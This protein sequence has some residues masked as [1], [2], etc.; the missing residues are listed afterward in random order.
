MKRCVIDTN[1]MVTANK[2]VQGTDDELI[3]K[4]PNLIIRCINALHRITKKGI[5]VVFDEGNEIFDE[6]KRHL[7][8]SGQPGVGDKF[9]KWMHNN[10]Y[11]YL[12]TEVRLHRTDNGYKEF[13]QGM[14]SANVDPSDKKFFAV[15]N[16]HPSKPDIYEAVDSKWWSWAATAKSCGINIIFLDELYM[17]EHEGKSK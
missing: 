4:H 14:E 7:N 11:K 12:D 9:F 2:A 6:Y 8:F 16:A 5:F 1:V 13:P 10:R 17:I 15:S 3:R